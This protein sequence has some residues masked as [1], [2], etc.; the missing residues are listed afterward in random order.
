MGVAW[1][2]TAMGMERLCIESDVWM[3]SRARNIEE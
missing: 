1:T 3:G 2:V